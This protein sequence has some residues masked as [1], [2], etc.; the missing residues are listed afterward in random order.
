MAISLRV[1]A[2][3][4]RTNPAPGLPGSYNLNR[5]RAQPEL[6]E[7]LRD[8]LERARDRGAVE[9]FRHDD[10]VPRHET[11]AFQRSGEESFLPP[12]LHRTVGAQDVDAAFVGAF[13]RG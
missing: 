3:A 13:G 10:A 1:P 4:H 5:R 6:V 7:D 9:L 2:C 11:R 12:A 8:V